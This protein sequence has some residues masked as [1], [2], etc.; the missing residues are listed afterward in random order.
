[1]KKFLAA[2]ILAFGLVAGANA[3]EVFVRV[4]PPR[5]HREVM[6]VRP[7]PRHVWIPGHY[8]WTHGRYMWVRGYWVMPPRPHA[9]WVPGYWAPRHHGYVWVAGYWR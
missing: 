4:G 9:V 8:Q 5:P 7:G 6:V 1:M 3:A 2:G